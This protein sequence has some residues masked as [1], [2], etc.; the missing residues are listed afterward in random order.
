MTAYEIIMIFLGIIGSLISF[1]YRN[2]YVLKLQ[3]SQNE[4]DSG[5]QAEKGKDVSGR[6]I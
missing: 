1:G 6:R 2:I 5:R 3:N 4:E